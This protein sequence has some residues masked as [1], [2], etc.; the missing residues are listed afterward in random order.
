MPRLN[1]A[2]LTDYERADLSALPRPALE[3]LAWQFRELARSLANR[4]GEDSTTS[5]R[6]PSSDDPFRRDQRGGKAPAGQ[7]AA[8]PAGKK[9][10][11]AEDETPAKPPGKRPGTPGHWRRQPI[12]VSREVAHVPPVCEACQAVLGAERQGRQVSA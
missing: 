7:D 4:L 11:A 9:A 3:D 1:I 6:P 8:A 10:K 12:V 2:D 5:S